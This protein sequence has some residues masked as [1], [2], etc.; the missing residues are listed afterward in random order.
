MR[1]GSVS[2]NGRILTLSRQRV[3]C[4]FSDLRSGRHPATTSCPLM[5]R[6]GTR[7]RPTNPSAPVT[8][9]FTVSGPY[10]SGAA[11]PL[12]VGVDHHPD[13]LIEAYGRIPAQLLLGSGGIRLQNID[14]GRPH[15]PGIADHKFRPIQ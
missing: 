11:E 12:E 4:W 8:R 3:S 10:S 1:S 7:C 14:L 13:Q 6:R 2:S 5:T 9:I 15:V